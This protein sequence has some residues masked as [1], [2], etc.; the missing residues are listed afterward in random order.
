MSTED[1]EESAI[2]RFE[3]ISMRWARAVLAFIVGVGCLAILCGG[4]VAGG[5]WLLPPP[6]PADKGAPPVPKKFALSMAETWSADHT[7]AKQAMERAVLEVPAGATVPSPLAAFFP[8]PVFAASDEWEEICRS[9]TDYGCVQKAKRL[10]RPAA[11]RTFAALFRQMESSE[12]SPIVEILAAHLGSIPTEKRLEMVAPIMFAFDDLRKQN[13]A[14]EAAYRRH[15]E[16]I[17]ARFDEDMKGHRVRQMGLSAGGLYS[18]VSGFVSVVSASMFI[19][20]L[21]IERHLR[22]LRLMDEPRIAA[23]VRSAARSAV[24]SD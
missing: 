5:A 18:A 3:R 9:M 22:G 7:Q 12:I 24:S 16:E 4:A 15:I 19:A 8:A 11:G 13:E 17:D 20:L 2:T 14:A 6:T 21:A 1:S 10:V 23:K